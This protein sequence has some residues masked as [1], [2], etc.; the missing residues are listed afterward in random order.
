[1]L[2]HAGHMVVALCASAA[3]C[4]LQPIS[5]LAEV[6]EGA[7][8]VAKAAQKP[9]ETFCD[10]TPFVE[11]FSQKC[12][13]EIRQANEGGSEPVPSLVKKVVDVRMK[14]R[15]PDLL[16]RFDDALWKAFQPWY[17][18]L[19]AGPIEARTVA[20]E[21]AIAYTEQLKI[22][23]P[24]WLLDK[25]QVEALRKLEA[26][27]ASGDERAL[28]EAVVFAKQTDHKADEA[29]ESKYEEALTK[30]KRLKRLPSGWEVTELVGDDAST[31]MFKKA[32]LDDPALKQLFQ[33][34]FDDTKASIVTRDRAARGAGAMPRGYRVQKIISVMNAE[35]WQ[36][37]A[38]RRDNIAQD[39]RL[40]PGCAPLSDTAW[41]DWSGKIHTAPHGN[42]ILEGAHLP[43]LSAGANEFLMFHGTNPEAADLIAMNH[44]DM[45]F[46]CKSGL[47]GAGLYFAEN[48]S[49]SDEY[50][51]G[52]AKGW[53]P[54]I[55]CRVTLGRIY[56]C[57]NTDPT[58]D[59]GRDKLEAACTGG[60]YHCVLGDRLKARG[61]Y[62][63]YVLYD[64]Y[65]VYPQFI[66]WYTRI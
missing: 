3:N 4:K 64:H 1:M 41:G 25:D 9:L 28:R 19:Q 15:Q 24:K 53:Y 47:F 66:V 61:T 8:S 45:A 35:S 39:C 59:P 42:A 21:F 62:R 43:S 55:L 11:S 6:L 40:Y 31:K 56:Y 14:F 33:K 20:A 54:M 17:K 30:L 22:Q 16:A 58:T 18:E 49:K 60:S 37:Y 7:E 57:A 26:A 46:A 32:D 29:L 38:E 65:Q 12:M 51:K 63:E 36:S 10:L 52:D 13:Q 50:V 27:V 5:R 44:F 48:S 23:L 2:S 34:L